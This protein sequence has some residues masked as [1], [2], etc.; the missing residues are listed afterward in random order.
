[1][2][3]RSRK[4]SVAWYR[5]F[6]RLCRQNNKICLSVW[7]FPVQSTIKLQ[8]SCN[9]LPQ[10]RRNKRE[11]SFL[12]VPPPSNRIISRNRCFRYFFLFFR[13]TGSS[14]ATTRAIF[15]RRGR[16]DCRERGKKKFI[17]IWLPCERETGS[18]M[19]CRWRGSL[20]EFTGTGTGGKGTRWSR[21]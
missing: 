15:T 7:S 17:N 1:M 14:L 6:E 11:F 4:N 13:Y 18:Q 21:S 12:E 9:I 20:R 19:G 2:Q 8:Y 10:S 3:V 5:V 16:G